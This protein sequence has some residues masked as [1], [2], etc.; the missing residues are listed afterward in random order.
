MYA[1]P[2]PGREALARSDL[3]A[4]RSLYGG[5]AAGPSDLVVM[6][7]GAHPLS[8]LYAVAPPEL[9][10]WTLFDTDGDGDEEVLVWRTDRAGQGALWVFHFAN[11]P[12][13][14]RTVGP[15]YGVV[16]P[17]LEPSFR[18]LSSGER[19]L[20]LEPE[21]GSAQ[22]RVFDDHGIPA[23]HDGEVPPV[24]AMEHAE[25]L[26]GDLDGDGRRETVARGR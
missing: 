25:T 9:T 15:L 22:A 8:T 3:C 7:S 18:R 2:S 6:D 24:T 23:L 12:A 16:G 14:E 26:A 20:I 17:G 10:G 1:E 11:G 13:L 5:G 21:Q 4:L 19:V